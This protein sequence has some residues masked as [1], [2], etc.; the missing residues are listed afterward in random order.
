MKGKATSIGS[1]NRIIPVLTVLVLVAVVAAI[2]AFIFVSRLESHAEQYLQRVAEQQVLAQKVAKHA[3]QASVGGKSAF[4][5]LRDDRDR[6]ITLLDQLK[7]GD[8]AIGLPAAP[9]QVETELRG[10]DDQWLALRALVDDILLNQSAILSVREFSDVITAEI[11]NLQ[12]A[13][14]E[15]AKALVDGRR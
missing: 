9:P 3:L 6:F 2:V 5:R 7:I 14:E 15:V 11:P 1:G 12:K 8:P 10:V 13:S 4:E